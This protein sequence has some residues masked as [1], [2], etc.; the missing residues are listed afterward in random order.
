MLS[1]TEGAFL[2]AS[3]VLTELRE[4]EYTLASFTLYSDGSGVLTLPMETHPMDDD[5]AE[6]LEFIL[7]SSRWGRNEHGDLTLT[8]CYGLRGE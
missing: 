4:M 3:R 8:T 6:F 2:K 7:G 1:P 5:I